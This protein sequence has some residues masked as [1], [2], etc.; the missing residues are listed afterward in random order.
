ML[1]S[2]SKLSHLGRRV[3]REIN[4]RRF[5]N[6]SLRMPSHHDSDHCVAVAKIY[7]GAE[8]KMKAYRQRRH[9]CSVKLPCGPQGELETISEELC[10]D[11]AP[12]PL[13]R[14]D[15]KIKGF[16]KARGCSSI[17]GRR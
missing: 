7:S 2:R 12:P 16:P 13:T 14:R 9:C 5:C 4:H 1:E 3:G 15:P 10:M 11:I 6:I 17:N 8:K